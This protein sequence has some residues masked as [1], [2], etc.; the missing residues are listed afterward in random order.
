[1][2]D[3]FVKKTEMS[4]EDHKSYQFIVKKLTEMEKELCTLIQELTL[5]GGYNTI[6][7]VGSWLV[8]IRD[9]REYFEREIIKNESS[10]GPF[11]SYL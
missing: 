7:Y 1:M 3:D 6:N 2:N 4:N 5:I 9:R 10:S 8:Q 11:S